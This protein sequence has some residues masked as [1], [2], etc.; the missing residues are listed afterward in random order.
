MSAC[1]LEGNTEG[2]KTAHF[3]GFRQTGTKQRT[4]DET[5]HHKNK[6]KKNIRGPRPEETQRL[7]KLSTQHTSRK[8]TVLHS[9]EETGGAATCFWQM[10]VCEWVLINSQFR[11]YPLRSLQQPAWPAICLQ[12]S[13]NAVKFGQTDELRSALPRS[14]NF[15]FCRLLYTRLRLAGHGK[16]MYKCCD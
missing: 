1:Q 2:C 9:T 13:Q 15:L 7:S 8:T 16:Q 14:Y 5:K 3:T 10:K 6:C 11:N 4:W 12:H